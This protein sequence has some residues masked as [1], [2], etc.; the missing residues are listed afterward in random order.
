MILTAP[1]LQTYVVSRAVT[2]QIV[3]QGRWL[4][5][6]SVSK[7]L[8]LTQFH[9]FTPLFDWKKEF[10]IEKTCKKYKK[11]AF[12]LKIST[13]VRFDI[14]SVYTI[15]AGLPW[16]FLNFYGVLQRLHWITQASSQVCFKWMSKCVIWIAWREFGVTLHVKYFR[17]KWVTNLSFCHPKI[18]LSFLNYFS[19]TSFAIALKVSFGGRKRI[20]LFMESVQSSLCDF[21]CKREFQ[22]KN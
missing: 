18:Y 16:K 4:V 13:F 15:T 22:V 3:T 5:E 14:G 17:R 11:R 19:T 2:E 6:F 20:F 21:V 10:C 7:W 8:K 1:S 12:R 9:L